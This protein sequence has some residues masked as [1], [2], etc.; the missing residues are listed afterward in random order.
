[1]VFSL[2]N[3]VNYVNDQV[4]KTEAD[5]GAAFRKDVKEAIKL[6]GYPTK[7]E[8]D[9]VDTIE[10]LKMT[11]TAEQIPMLVGKYMVDEDRDFEIP[12]VDDQTCGA[13][14]VRVHKDDVTKT[15]TSNMNGV[16][17]EWTS[18]VVAHNEYFVKNRR[19]PFKK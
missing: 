19:K 5:L 1:M 13:A 16:E 17:K 11:N 7:E 12:A 18:T 4:N 15:G 14:I 2:S 3:F 6:C 9:I 8:I 10:G